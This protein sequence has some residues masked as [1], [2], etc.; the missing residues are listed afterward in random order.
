MTTIN[1]IKPHHDFVSHCCEAETSIEAKQWICLEC[2]QECLLKVIIMD[3]AKY[4]L[5]KS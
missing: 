5:Q 1:R 2:E 3:F 4:T